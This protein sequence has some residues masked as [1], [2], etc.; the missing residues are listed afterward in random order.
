MAESIPSSVSN[1]SGSATKV[2]REIFG[3]K[4]FRIVSRQL[5]IP[6]LHP[7]END[8]LKVGQDVLTLAQFGSP[9]S[10]FFIQPLDTVMPD[11][12][13]AEPTQGVTTNLEGIFAFL[14][15]PLQTLLMPSMKFVKFVFTLAFRFES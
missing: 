7:Q 5:A 13:Q 2:S 11:F 8:R 6:C 15:F 4:F 14:L 1:P 12:G 10:F 9:G 3:L